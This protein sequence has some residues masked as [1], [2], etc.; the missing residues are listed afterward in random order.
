MVANQ[1]AL[2]RPFT[3]L[4]KQ[5]YGHKEATCGRNGAPTWLMQYRLDY[6]QV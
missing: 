5:L 6:A 3:P 4:G 2:E 1:E